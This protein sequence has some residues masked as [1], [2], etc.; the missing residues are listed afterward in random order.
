MRARGLR[1]I[2]TDPQP[3][4]VEGNLVVRLYWQLEAG[5]TILWK[6]SMNDQIVSE[7]KEYLKLT[8]GDKAA[9]ASLVVADA[10]LSG[11]SMSKPKAEPEPRPGD[12]LVSEAAGQLRCS[13]MTIYRLCKDGRLPHYRVGAGRGVIR[14]RIADLAACQQICRSLPADIS[15]KRRR[16][17]GV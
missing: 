11:R 10:L 1:I 15:A 7:Y 6:A 9:A 5:R 2:A 13:E 14:I 4:G 8:G 3:S 17:L 12:L 16:Y